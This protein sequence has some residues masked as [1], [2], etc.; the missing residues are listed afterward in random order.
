MPFVSRKIGRTKGFVIVTIGL[1]FGLLQ[2]LLTIPMGGGLLYFVLIGAIIASLG[3]LMVAFRNKLSKKVK[4]GAIISAVILLVAVILS[5][6]QFSVMS[7][8]EQD[9]QEVRESSDDIDSGN[10]EEKKSE[11][12]VS[13][14][15]FVNNFLLFVFLLATATSLM[16]IAVAIPSLRGRDK[17]RFLMLIPLVMAV[18]AII[19]AS[20]ITNSSLN[21]FR[22]ILDDFEAAE[23]Q[24]DFEDVAEEVEDID[25]MGMIL[26]SRIGGILNFIAILIAIILSYIVKVEIEEATA[27][28]Q[29]PPYQEPTSFNC[30]HCGKPFTAQQSDQAQQVSCPSCSGQVT[31]SPLP[32]P[33]LQY[34]AQ[35]PP[36]QQPPQPPPPPPLQQPVQ[37][38]QQPSQKPQQQL[39]EPPTQ[40]QSTQPSSQLVMEGEG[41]LD[42]LKK[43]LAKGEIDLKTY[44]ELKKELE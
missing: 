21:E 15:N 18:L 17:K 26:G 39:Q 5:F 25:I 34:P 19:M 36:A 3:F 1:V 11:V 12:L 2:A 38:P 6:I 8:V 4:M 20:I 14:R 40:F 42:I 23:T 30:P 9:I 22:G 13:M 41:P 37:E 16:V 7:Q 43:R 31:I 28:M 29:Y 33:Q 10:W 35:E 32:Q 27:P 24:W 44:R